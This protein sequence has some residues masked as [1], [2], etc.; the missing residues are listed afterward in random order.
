MLD[1]VRA[2]EYSARRI[3]GA[4]SRQSVTPESESVLWSLLSK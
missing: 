2:V 1:A 3:P 4:V